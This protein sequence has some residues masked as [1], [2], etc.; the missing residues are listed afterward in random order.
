[1]KSMIRF[2]IS[3]GFAIALSLSVT[4]MVHA[5]RRGGG[6]GG[7]R[8]SMGHVG[9]GGGRPSMGGGGMSNMSRPSHNMSR[10]SPNLSRP[11]PSQVGANRPS[12]GNVSRPNVSSPGARP[13]MPS[14]SGGGFHPSGGGRPNNSLP[15]VKPG[16]S[17]TANRP[18][19]KLPSNLQPTTRPSLPSTGIGQGN[20]PTTL[21]GTVNRPGAGM[22]RPNIGNV[23]RPVTLPGTVNRPGAGANRPSIGNLNRPATL[24]GTMDRPGAGADRPNIGNL[25]RPTTLP[26]TVNRPNIGSGNNNIGS[27]NNNRPIIGGGNRP[28]IGNGINTGNINIGNTVNIGNG[29]GN[30]IGNSIG[31]RGG[32]FATTLPAWDRPGYNRP[33][34]GLGGPGNG[35]WAGNWHD[36]CINSHHGWYNG[37]WNHGYWGSSWYRPVAW[38]SVGWGLNSITRG[39][40]YGY[41]YYNPYYVAPVNVASVPYDYSQPIVVNNYL[42]AASNAQG[43]SAQVAQQTTETPAS[44]SAFDQGLEQFKSGNYQKALATFDVSLKQLPSDPVVHEVRA[45]TLFALGQYTP[46]A[47]SLN[48]L[49]SSAPGMDWTT[50]SSLYGNA[51]DYTKQLR[52]LEQF[53]KSNQNDAAAAFVLSYHYLVLGEK[54]G[55]IGSLQT[56]VKLQPK[57][58]TA[59]RMLDAL[60][61]PKA[62]ATT[63]DSADSSSTDL[64]G[65]WKAT[66]GDTAITLSIAE[67]SAF[68]W[69]ATPAGQ[70]VVEL[71]GQITADNDAIVLVNE[72]QGSMA[73]T[74]K[75]GG[76]DQWKFIL[77]GAPPDD[78]GLSFQRV[79]KGS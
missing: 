69:K 49:L 56:V 70:P 36:H 52:A 53:C 57:D 12:F 79:G 5:Q 74:V 18:S 64:V 40:G 29:S 6:G 19:I 4:T 7:A 71:Q 42:P 31:N 11:S 50:M 76:A 67:D 62:A 10:P 46:A 54:E 27:G 35:N 37:C 32:N 3:G 16:G 28:S 13:N 78:P 73:G 58:S 33:G 61:P 1:M 21:P 22:D 41:A 34:W 51:D 24:P 30:S 26:G 23:D 20:R 75:S 63:T 59:K 9:G 14:V 65:N 15:S 39:W 44:L 45:L 25:N 2:I 66:V 43:A 68:V 77:E 60:L 38:A 55:A 72:K 17:G 8:P 48:S 47:A